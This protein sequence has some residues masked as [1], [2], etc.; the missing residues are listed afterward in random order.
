MAASPAAA[1]RRDRIGARLRAG[2][3]VSLAAVLVAGIAIAVVLVA[4]N[5]DEGGDRPAQIELVYPAPASSVLR[6]ATV[7]VDLVPAWSCHLTIDGERIPDDEIEGAAELGECFFRP[8]KGKTFEEFGTG[9][10]TVTAVIF[11]D[12]APADTAEY[13]WSF[14]VT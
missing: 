2:V 1:S 3:A 10:H 4:N 5:L 9:E 6:Q 11:A 14:R 13:T 8:G 7:G 12:A